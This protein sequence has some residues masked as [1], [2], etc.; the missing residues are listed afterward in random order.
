MRTLF[1]IIF[2]ATVH[3]VQ[4]Q[5]TY[6]PSRQV[7][8][9]FLISP[10]GEPTYNLIYKDKIVI[11][12]SKLGFE[13]EDKAGEKNTFA[14]ETEQKA[15]EARSQMYKGF[16]IK[17]IVESTFDEVWQPVWGEENKIRNHYNEMAV[18]L[19][20]PATGRMMVIRFRVFDD[21][22]GFRYEFPMQNNLIYFTVKEEKTQFSLQGDP[23]AYWI[24]GD[25]DTQEY[26]YTISK[27]SEI[28]QNMKTA[29]T[30]N[31]SQT[32]FSETGVQTPF[33]L[34]T[35]SGLYISLHE[36]ALINYGR[37]ALELQYGKQFVCLLDNA[38]CRWY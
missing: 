13:L 2:L 19:D 25:Y 10:D 37:H 12:D 14:T 35:E 17:D 18:F 32:P 8:L 23:M 22:L 30:P 36:A 4:S 27:V 5:T 38:G 7:T 6:S 20:H 1:L 28:K 33:L 29:I 16:K 34:K 26:D 24:P 11:S 21:G 9:N 15:S 31:A 3:L